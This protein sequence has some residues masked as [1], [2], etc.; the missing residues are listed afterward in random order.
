[1]VLFLGHIGVGIIGVGR[2]GGFYARMLSGGIPGAK[3]IAVAGHTAGKDLAASLGVRWYDDYR[4]MLKS[5]DIDMVMIC[6]QTPSHADLAVAAANAGKHVFCEK[7]IALTLADADR[8]I[9]TAL[10]NNIKLTVGFM[11]RFDPSYASVKAQITQGLLGIPISLRGTHRSRLPADWVLKPDQGGGLVIDYLAHEY[12]LARWLLGSEVS[13]VYCVG[14]ALVYREKKKILPGFVDQV[15]VLMQMES[16][17]TAAIEAS[18][19]AEYAYDVR[20][21]VLGSKGLA[22]VGELREHATT[23]Y[24][25]PDGGTFTLNRSFLRRFEEAFRRQVEEFVTS[26]REDQQPAVTGEDGR[27]ALKIGLAALLSL[28]EGKPIEL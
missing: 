6:T 22:M 24:T 13:R 1:M 27:E 5:P 7:P 11:R 19:A 9:E 21:E 28:R 15:A 12:D 26:I 2:M 25:P 3:L 8:V 14:E 23:T 17:A 20:T 4:T 18:C 10:V 16:G